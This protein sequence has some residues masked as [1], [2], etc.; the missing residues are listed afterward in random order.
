MKKSIIISSTNGLI[1]VGL[2]ENEQVCELYI[3][4]DRASRLLGNIYVGT[5]MDLIPSMQAAFIDLGLE[6]NAFLY[7][8]DV[9]PQSAMGRE[10]LEHTQ[11][12]SI[13]ATYCPFNSAWLGEHHP[14]LVAEQI[15]AAEAGGCDGY[16]FYEGAA[17]MVA[18]KDGTV[19]MTQPAL[20]DVFR[21]LV[22]RRGTG[23]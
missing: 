18:G 10:V 21:S 3:E 11:R 12:H 20:R 17:V 4:R 13:P 9:R 2:I 8:K 6:K 15:E 22:P 23:T 5:V 19:R 1:C 16:Q 14:A 7:L